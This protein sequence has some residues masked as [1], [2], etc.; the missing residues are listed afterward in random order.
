[1]QPNEPTLA[2]LLREAETVR[3]QRAFLEATGEELLDRARV[4]SQTA[5]DQLRG[6]TA[7]TSVA[8]QARS[9]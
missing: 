5:E 6:G 4:L 8:E 9:R 2:T 7:P 1:M 3:L